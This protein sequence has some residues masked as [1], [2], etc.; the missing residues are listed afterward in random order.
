MFQFQLL[1][2]W[3]LIGRH[4]INDISSLCL[5]CNM[6]GGGTWEGKGRCVCQCVSVWVCVTVIIFKWEDGCF[7]MMEYQLSGIRCAYVWLFLCFDSYQKHVSSLQLKSTAKWRRFVSSRLALVQDE[8]CAIISKNEDKQT[9][10]DTFS[11][12][13]TVSQERSDR[14]PVSVL[15][16]T[17]I[18]HH[19]P[20]YLSKRSEVRL[21]SPEIDRIC[22]LC[23]LSRSCK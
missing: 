20:L 23:Y 1:F 3:Q 21:S 4:E 10:E 8:D 9:N 15:N 2:R 5:H 17:R 13:L 11:P 14:G 16:P 7:R 6:K 22:L 18:P 19:S 12:L